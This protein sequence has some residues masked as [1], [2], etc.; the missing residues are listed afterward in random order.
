MEDLHAV[1][2]NAEEKEILYGAT[3]KK[4]DLPLSYLFYVEDAVFVGEWSQFNARNIVRILRCFYLISGHKINIQKSKLF[5]IGVDY[6]ELENMARVVGCGVSKIPFN[7]LRLPV[8]CNMAK[9]N[10]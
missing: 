4:G 7:Y 1:I 5:S 9:I 8:G 10:A 2:R 3:I 6:V